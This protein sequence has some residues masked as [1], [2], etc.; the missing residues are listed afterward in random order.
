MI[1][2]TLGR[3]V[4]EA[5]QILDLGSS[6]QD[7]NL[8]KGAETTFTRCRQAAATGMTVLCATCFAVRACWP[9]QPSGLSC[10]ALKCYNMAKLCNANKEV[11]FVY[12]SR[13]AVVL[14][15][16]SIRPCLHN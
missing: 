2:L 7:H 12:L 8:K 10:N 13:D 6:R 1:T 15:V 11:R 3:S 16:L 4:Q 14:R 9:V 5:H